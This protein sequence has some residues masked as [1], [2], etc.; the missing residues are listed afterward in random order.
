MEIVLDFA[1]RLTKTQINRLKKSDYPKNKT[2]FALYCELDGKYN[3]LYFDEKKQEVIAP[4][5]A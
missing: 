4:I 3:Q 1:D 2:F 5:T